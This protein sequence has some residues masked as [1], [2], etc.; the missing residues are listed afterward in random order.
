M[1]YQQIAPFRLALLALCV[2]CSGSANAVTEAEYQANK[3]DIDLARTYAAELFASGKYEQALTVIEDVIIAKPVDLAAR[4]FRIQVMVALGRGD[5]VLDELE[6]MTTLKLPASDKDRA[7]SLIA[8]IKKNESPL[9]AMASL[10]IGLSHADNAN[11]YPETGVGSTVY[12]V[13]S[14]SFVSSGTK[15]DN[16]NGGQKKLS[17]TI[18]EVTLG[19]F[20][21]YRLND[22][23]TSKLNFAVSMARKAGDETINSDGSTKLARL[24]YERKYG[25]F[26]TELAYSYVALDKTNKS[27]ATGT[28]QDVAPDTK[29]SIPSLSFSYR[30]ANKMSTTYSYSQMASTNSGI[31]D[32]NYYDGTTKKHSISLSSPVGSSS[33]LTTSYAVNDY[34]ADLAA[35]NNATDKEFSTLSASLITVWAK[36]HRTKVSYSLTNTEFKNVNTSLNVGSGGVK[37]K[38]DKSAFS[39]NYI[40]GGDYFFEAL[41]DWSFDVG[42]SM[43]ET[44]SNFAV[45]DVKNNTVLLKAER[46]WSH[47]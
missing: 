40:I 16:S 30:F 27:S 37:R 33:L 24:G 22:A 26:S 21:S 38:D 34:T 12:D 1:K 19:Y 28:S 36:G 15:T 11:S 41:K 44:D 18:S 43:T 42:Y 25:N 32:A 31:A 7:E 23:D 5:E 10:K 17:D 29:L 4:F 14:S 46:R 39:L 6:F 47:Y 3:D 20:G 35:A 2:L 13:A 8:L 45:Y 9:N